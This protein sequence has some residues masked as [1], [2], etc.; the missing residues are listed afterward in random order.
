MIAAAFCPSLFQLPESREGQQ[1]P[2]AGIIQLPYSMVFAL[3]TLDS[4]LLY[5][6]QVQLVR[7]HA[8]AAWCFGQGRPIQVCFDRQGADAVLWPR[9]AGRPVTD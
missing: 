7:A 2:T 1:G 6:T 9:A 3:A 8:A 4:L 5:S